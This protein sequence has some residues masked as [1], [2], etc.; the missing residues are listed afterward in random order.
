M[1][2]RMGGGVRRSEEERM[3]VHEGEDRK[4]HELV[5]KEKM[6]CAF[7]ESCIREL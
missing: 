7:E 6:T 3:G 5:K 4:Q 1:I 2:K